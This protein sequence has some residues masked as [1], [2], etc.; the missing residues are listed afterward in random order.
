[1]IIVYTTFKQLEI[2]SKFEVVKVKV[3][4]SCPTLCDP[5]DYLKLATTI[6]FILTIKYVSS[7]DSTYRVMGK[8]IFSLISLLGFLKLFSLEHDFYTH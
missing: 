1:M 6:M 4:Q 8:K 5:M 7:L 2:E 3:A